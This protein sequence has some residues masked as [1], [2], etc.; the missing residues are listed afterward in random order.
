[1]SFQVFKILTKGWGEEGRYPQ[2]KGGV[3]KTE[4]CFKKWGI[5]LIFIL[6]NPFQCNKGSYCEHITGG[7]NIYLY[8]RHSLLAPEC[9]VCF[10]VHVCVCV[11]SNQST[12]KKP[13]YVSGLSKLDA[14]L[15]KALIK[16]LLVLRYQG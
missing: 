12:I 13:P 11:T 10:C 6:T 4:G 15:Y 9:A 14:L 3:G 16:V 7:I 1:M 5:L 8:D 2:K